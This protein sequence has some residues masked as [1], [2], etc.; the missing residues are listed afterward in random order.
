MDPPGS[1]SR[2]LNDTLPRSLNDTGSL[3]NNVTPARD[4]GELEGDVEEKF[5]WKWVDLE[6]GFGEGNATSVDT[7]IPSVVIMPEV[8]RLVMKGENHLLA[9]LIDRGQ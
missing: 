5:Q 1:P 8:M 3:Q 9:E 6:S 2:S 4:K 7:V